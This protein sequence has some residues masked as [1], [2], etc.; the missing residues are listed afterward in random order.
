MTEHIYL[1]YNA[2]SPLHPAAQEAMQNAFDAPSNPSSVHHHGRVARAKL[3][4]AREQCATLL[5]GRARDITFTSGGTEANNM[6]L[7]GY[8]HVICS[9]IEHDAVLAACP[10]ADQIK[11]L[12]NGVI[13]LSDLAAKLARITPEQSADTVVSVMAANNETG[14]I[15]PIAQIA[16]LCREAGVK[17]HSDMVQ[18]LGKKPLNVIELGVDY[19]SFSAH[20]IGGP[21]GVGAVYSAGAL[22]PTPLIKGGGQEQ[23]SRSGTENFLGIIGFGEAAK[24]AVDGALHFEQLEIWRNEAE[25]RL[26][27]AC[28]EIEVI[29]QDADRLGNTS[30]LYLPHITSEM[31]VMSL[32]LKGFSISAGAACSSG[33]M[34]PS[35]VIS[36]M[37]MADKAGHVIRISSGWKTQANDMLR[38]AE[39]IIE[40]YKH[41]QAG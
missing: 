17:F 8:Q 28:P 33:K 37:G 32:D 38:L 3:E 34:K 26:V 25:Q 16:M 1:D 22:R 30:A 15:Q 13:D 31:A 40:M 41:S 2:T 36:A 23:G 29:A 24:A 4:K 20:K 27:S 18:I 35:H 21:S 19:A 11:T 39:Q 9:E 5:G 14:A 12:P 10:D 6:V 7:A